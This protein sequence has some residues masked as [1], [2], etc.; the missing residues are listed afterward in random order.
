MEPTISDSAKAVT[1]KGFG[2]TSNHKFIDSH[3]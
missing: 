1:E 3:M 2:Q